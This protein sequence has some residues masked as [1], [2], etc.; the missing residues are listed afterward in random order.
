MH[1]ADTWVN[2]SNLAEQAGS[3]AL[4][5]AA[6]GLA[7]VAWEGVA[8]RRKRLKALRKTAGNSGPIT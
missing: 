5:I 4:C 2:L 8:A 6:I 3:V 1:I 7:C